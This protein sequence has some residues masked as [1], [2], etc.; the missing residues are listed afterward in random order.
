M[1][2][3][4]KASERNRQMNTTLIKIMSN[5]ALRY[6]ARIGVPMNEI[7]SRHRFDAMCARRELNRRDYVATFGE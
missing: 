5:D 2:Y 6:C 3:K 4:I 1:R 7:P